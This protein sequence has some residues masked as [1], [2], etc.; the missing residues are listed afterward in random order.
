[1]ISP[2]TLTRPHRSIWQITLSSPPDNRLTPSL[3]SSLSSQLDTVESEWRSTGEGPGDPGKGGHYGPGALVLTSGC[4]RFFCN[5]LDWEKSLT[6]PYFF[7]GPP[8]LACGDT[9]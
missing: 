4:E 6:I 7:E 3:L 5:G 9:G 8:L 2:T 1:M